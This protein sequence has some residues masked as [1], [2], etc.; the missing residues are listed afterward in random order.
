VWIK[1]IAGLKAKKIVW[2]ES[3]LLLDQQ[4]G[5]DD[6]DDD[7]D[8]NKYFFDDGRNKIRNSCFSNNVNVLRVCFASR[9]WCIGDKIV[10]TGG[11]LFSRC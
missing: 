5:D 9:R 2:G 10:R 8:N 1:K 11:P 3:N 4:A 7:D 6:D